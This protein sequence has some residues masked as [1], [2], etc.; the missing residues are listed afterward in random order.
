[1][2]ESVTTEQETSSHGRQG[3]S[4]ARPTLAEL[5]KR[6]RELEAENER[7]RGLLISTWGSDYA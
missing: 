3:S 2:E 6:L 4:G 7:L 5:T 1:M